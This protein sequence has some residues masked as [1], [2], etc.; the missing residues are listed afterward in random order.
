MKYPP[1]YT[2]GNVLFLPTTQVSNRDSD[3][4]KSR[5][6]VSILMDALKLRLQTCE[7]KHNSVYH[8]ALSGLS[9]NIAHP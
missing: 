1:S 4:S 3:N 6:V 5:G 2:T 8:A 9:L 7:K